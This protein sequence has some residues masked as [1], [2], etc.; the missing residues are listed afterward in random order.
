MANTMAHQKPV[1]VL[2]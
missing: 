2:S 1:E